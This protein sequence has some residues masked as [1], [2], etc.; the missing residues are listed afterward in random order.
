MSVNADPRRA[1]NKKSDL[2][3]Q[4]S[5]EDLSDDDVNFMGANAGRN[6]SAVHEGG[7]PNSTNVE[8]R[9]RAREF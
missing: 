5:M 4:K 1:G 2:D 6:D 7:R 8:R 3:T 9:N